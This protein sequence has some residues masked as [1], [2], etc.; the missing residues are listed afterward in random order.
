MSAQIAGPDNRSFVM[1]L[2]TR[3]TGNRSLLGSPQEFAQS[4]K[5]LMFSAFVVSGSCGLAVDHVPER[6]IRIAMNITLANGQGARNFSCLNKSFVSV[7]TAKRVRY[8]RF[9][10]FE[11]TVPLSPV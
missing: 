4:G 8:P 5:T 9:L 1:A 2:G 3:V 7:F 10:T 6:R 11:K